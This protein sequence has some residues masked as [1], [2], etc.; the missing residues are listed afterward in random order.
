MDQNSPLPELEVEALIADQWIRVHARESRRGLTGQETL[1]SWDPDG[2]RRVA[3]EAWVENA[4]I[5]AVH[6]NE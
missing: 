1:V 4:R 2:P 5:R 3:R 6:L